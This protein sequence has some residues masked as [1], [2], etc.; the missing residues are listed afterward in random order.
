MNISNLLFVKTKHLTLNK[1]S[2]FEIRFVTFY[3]LT[4]IPSFETSVNVQ[5][6]GKYLFSE[7]QFDVSND[8]DDYH[9]I[10]RNNYEYEPN[11]Y[12]QNNPR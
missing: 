6:L 5:I 7:R 9:R 10:V 2:I 1:L 11:W 4:E 12:P 3:F 8:D